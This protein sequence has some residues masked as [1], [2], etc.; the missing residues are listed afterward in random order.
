MSGA[1]MNPKHIRAQKENK[2]PYE[3]LVLS[4]LESDARV[5]KSGGDKYGIRNWTIDEI[6]AST[7]VGA[8]CRHLFAW[9]QGEDLDP[10]SGEPHL[11][12]LR[13]CCAVV[14]DGDKHGKLIDDRLRAESKNPDEDCKDG[15]FYIV[16]FIRVC[17][18]LRTT[19]YKGPFPSLEAAENYAHLN[20]HRIFGVKSVHAVNPPCQE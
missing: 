6:L 19:T 13:A 17:G 10:D 11:T 2:I 3:Y 1:K 20:P 15:C 5:H 9:A 12:H 18:S 7:Y 16:Q 4:V 8:M 14:Q